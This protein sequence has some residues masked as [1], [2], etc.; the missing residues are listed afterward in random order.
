[1]IKIDSLIRKMTR[2]N[3]TA[4]EI[5]I[6]EAELFSDIIEQMNRE[7]LLQGKKADGTNMPDYVARSKTGKTGKIN[8][9]D[10]GNFQ[11]GFK[12]SKTSKISIDVESDNKM[13]LKKYGDIFGLN[14]SNLEIFRKTYLIPA[15]QKQLKKSIL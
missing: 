13:F 1:M 6:N 7:Q 8:L 3:D 11:A 2:F 9:F 15:M 14:K 5:A 10:T 4:E 12:A